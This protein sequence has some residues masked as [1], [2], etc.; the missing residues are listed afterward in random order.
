[1]NP[2]RKQRGAI[3]VAVSVGTLLSAGMK[4]A[5]ADPSVHIFAGNADSCI[6]EGQRESAPIAIGLAI[7]SSI[8]RSSVSAIGRYLNSAAQSTSSP[9]MITNDYVDLFRVTGESGK[10]AKIA[11]NFECLIVITGQFGELGTQG[12]PVNYA[13]GADPDGMFVKINN[14]QADVSILRRLGL[15]D[16]PN[17]YLEI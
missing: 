7:G 14:G 3:F 6:V 11:P 9:I 5:D 4:D 15:V 12:L 17:S 10:E 13:Q 16:L 8:I 1:M 2:S